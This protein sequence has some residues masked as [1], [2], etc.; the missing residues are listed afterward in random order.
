MIRKTV[1]YG[2]DGLMEWRVVL[3]AGATSV[4]VAFTGGTVT[5]Y[6]VAPA[7]FRTSDPI[8]QRIIEQSGY[9]R[10]G[11]IYICRRG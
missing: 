5:G 4:R 7:T 9:F 3:P 10:R 11:R 2:V 6:G 1:T 8:L